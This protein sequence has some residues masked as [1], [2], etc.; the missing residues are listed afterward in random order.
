MMFLKSLSNEFSWFIFLQQYLSLDDSYLPD[1]VFTSP[2]SPGTPP[3]LLSQSWGHPLTVKNRHSTAAP[4]IRH[5][6]HHNPME[7]I[8]Q[9]AQQNGK[10]VK[11]F[12]PY[13]R[14]SHRSVRGFKKQMSCP[15][16]AACQSPPV[17]KKKSIKAKTSKGRFI[18]TQAS[19]EML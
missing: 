16:Q 7:R 6:G 18:V 10:H 14:K 12:L 4:V 9:Y 19:E 11:M 3:D 8:S 17:V 5:R 13:A 2:A 1:P 15:A